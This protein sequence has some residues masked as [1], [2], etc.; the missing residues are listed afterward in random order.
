MRKTNVDAVKQ[1]IRNLL[2]TNKGERLFQPNLGGNINAM[3]FENITPQTFITMQDHIKDIL[4]AYE[5]RAEVIEVYVAETS[6]DHEV[7]VTIV[8]GIVNVQEPITLE[9]ILERVR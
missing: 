8:F 1:S 3:L 9:V 7:Q 6:D 5:P 4:A 2:L